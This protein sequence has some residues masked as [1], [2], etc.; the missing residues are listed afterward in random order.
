MDQN[1]YTKN[2]WNKVANA[3]QDKFLELDLY[4]ESY[5]IFCRHID[6]PEA[7]ILDVGCGPGNITKY[8]LTR[9]KAYRIKGLD[10]AANMVALAAKNNPGASFQLFDLRD[11]G[12]I[13]TKFGGIICGFCLPYLSS[14]ELEPFINNCAILLRPG[15]ICYW[16]FIDGETERS[17]WQTNKGGDRIYFNYHQNTHMKNLIEKCAFDILDEL[18]IT[19]TKHKNATELHTVLI[20]KKRATPHKDRSSYQEQAYHS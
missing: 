2:T 8:L 14:D 13:A 5:D 16:S 4:N 7:R 1:E 17:G 12:N 11:L 19:Y 15:G 10:Y 18:T 9:S 20:A 6:D 3:Y